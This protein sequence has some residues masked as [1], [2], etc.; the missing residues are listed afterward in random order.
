MKP[1][2]ASLCLAAAAA[3]LQP[4]TTHAQSG[5]LLK[6]FDLRAG[7]L[8]LDPNRPRLYVTLP[9]DNKLAV[10]DTDTNTVLTT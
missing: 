4:V 9:A 6:T 5:I 2:L 10:I 3:L 1:L 7:K 8:L